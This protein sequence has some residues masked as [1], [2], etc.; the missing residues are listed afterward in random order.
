[1]EIEELLVAIGVDTT[2]AAKIRDVVV[3]LGVAATQ[4]AREADQ[5][6]QNL[7]NIGNQSIQAAE[8]ATRRANEAGQSVGKLR[9]LAAGVGAL[10]GY[11]S[12][13][14]LGFINQAVNGARTLSKEKGLLFDIS[15]SELQ[16]AD[17]YQASMKR[18]GLSIESVKTKI[19]LNLL[20]QL[21]SAAS[22][23][24]NWL[25][26]NKELVAEGLTKTIQFGG[27]AVQVIINTGRAMGSV[28][29]N[30]I[31]WKGAL[32]VLTAAFAILNRTML[33]NPVTWI[34][35]A[36]IGLMLVVDDLMVYLD[37]GESQF[38]EFWGSCIDW[39]KRVQSWWNNLSGEF[40]TSLKLL[41]AMFAAAFGTN[42]FLTVT[43]GAGMFGRALSLL[44]SPFGKIIKLVGV[45]GK[46]FIW[47]GR[48]L[49]MNPI[50][51]I[52]A[53]VMGLGYVLYDLYKWL[54]TGESSFGDF[55]K[56]VQETWEKI[57]AFFSDGVKD[58]LKSLGMSDEGAEKTV[59]AIGE[60]F[61]LIFDLLTLPFR[62]GWEL[63]K[64]LFTVWSHDTDGFTTKI[65][66]TFKLVADMIKRPFEEAFNWV[67]KKYDDTVGKLKGL[68]DGAKGMVGLGDSDVDLKSQVLDLDQTIKTIT[69]S[70]S[71]AAG[72]AMIGN[73]V[74]NAITNSSKQTTVNNEINVTQHIASSDPVQAA[75]MST[76]GLES[77]LKQAGRNMEGLVGT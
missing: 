51:L 9:V 13:R 63:I 1:M 8:N 59:Q 4:I 48:A 46:A 26:A 21:T 20:P 54:K 10:I 69:Q 68:W 22:G 19:A 27:R 72:N 75:G 38:G 17:E 25:S 15:Q 37:G 28:I 61:S 65:G 74:T 34:I 66:N 24:N 67:T 30:T 2:Q 58:I 57:K 40:K 36:I 39:I 5:V 31:G 56:T 3:S 44:T 49:L 52:I 11:V 12:G 47:L 41:G 23:F 18:T 76:K 55:W 70:P 71:P 14:V 45:A 77:S 64:G 32:V 43:K 53:L 29:K 16:Q 62:Q 50:G 42:L 60:A 73:G 35:A 6:N 33:M 7:D